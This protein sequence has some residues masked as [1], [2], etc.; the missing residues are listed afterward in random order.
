MKAMLVPICAFLALSGCGIFAP[1]D[2]AARPSITGT[3]D[4]QPATEASV[5]AA[6]VALGSRAMRPEELDQT[7]PKEKAAALAVPAA[8]GEGLLGKVVVSLGSPAEQGL[9]L[10]TALVSAPVQGRV[11]TAAGVSLAVELR[12]GTG[13]ALLSL[14]A[15]QAL[16]LALTDLPEVAVYGP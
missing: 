11:V 9:W 10:K 2:Q 14:A 4:L 8:A 1:K 7:S 15:F 12:P 13:G 3:A 6:S 5:P 16:R